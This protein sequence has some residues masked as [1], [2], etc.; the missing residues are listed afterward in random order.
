MLFGPHFF[1]FNIYLEFG[2]HFKYLCML[3]KNIY[4][5]FGDGSP[6]PHIYMYTFW[7]W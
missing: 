6:R 1:F 3:P 4:T 7:R 2:P 5:H